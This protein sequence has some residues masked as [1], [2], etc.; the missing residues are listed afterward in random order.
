MPPVATELE[1][2]EYVGMQVPSLYKVMEV[3][4]LAHCESVDDNN[5]VKVGVGVRIVTGKL[6]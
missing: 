6:I 4:V 1:E 3:A 2:L 5:E